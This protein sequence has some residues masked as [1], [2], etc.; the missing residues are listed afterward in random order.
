MVP[1]LFSTDGGKA[2]SVS[3]EALA[4]ATDGNPSPSNHKPSAVLW[5]PHPGVAT[6]SPES[7]PANANNRATSP[8]VDAHAK[9]RPRQLTPNGARPASLG[10]RPLLSTSPRPGRSPASTRKR[11]RSP[12]R[13][14]GTAPRQVKKV[15]LASSRT[16][17]VPPRSRSSAPRDPPADGRNTSRPKLRDLVT[18]IPHKLPAAE[19]LEKWQVATVT[20]QVTTVNAA[21]LCFDTQG[22]PA[23][24]CECGRATS[25]KTAS[26]VVRCFNGSAHLQ[27]LQG[28]GLAAFA[29]NA[30][31]TGTADANWTRN[32]FRW[33][34]WKLAAM[35]R[36][37]PQHCGGKYLTS[38]PGT[39]TNATAIC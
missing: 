35:E 30:G 11:D 14:P 4:R 9:P 31:P 10:K 33:I 7:R 19:V 22:R 23:C 25:G 26:S 39:R 6:T 32:H 38:K 34:V 37:L 18:T 8:A 17:P 29:P 27:G 3:E 1:S 2:V 13:R 21:E 12:P 20:T 24:F 16:P 36:L 5:S 15:A 28:K